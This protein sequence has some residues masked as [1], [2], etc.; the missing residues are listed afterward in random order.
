MIGGFFF[1]TFFRKL[2]KHK[3]PFCVLN[4][5]FVTHYKRQIFMRLALVFVVLVAHFSFGGK[6]QKG[7]AA[8]QE[9]NYFKAKQLFEKSLKRNASPASYGLAIIYFR[10]DNP[11][12]SLDSAKRF[13]LKAEENYKFVKEKDRVK[14]KLLGVDSLTIIET[15]RQISSGFFLRA[16][17]ENSIEAYDLFIR[18]HPWSNELVEAMHLRDSMLVDEALKAN[19]S[20]I[21]ADFLK[22]Y[23]TSEYVK[24]IQTA[25]Y[26]SQYDEITAAGSI[27]S[28]L[29][30]LSK[31]PDSPHRNKA[32][33][34]IYESSTA[35]NTIEVYTSFLETYPENI[36]FGNAWRKVY[37]LFMIDFSE[38]RIEQFKE[39]FPAYP[40]MDE[41]NADAEF[42][43]N[44]LLP[45]K[46]GSFYGFINFEG[47]QI[48]KAEYE[49][50]GFFKEGLAVAMKGGKYGYIDKGNRLVID[51]LFDN[52]SDFE[53][54]RAIVEINEKSGMID[55]AGNLVLE[56]VF[57]DLGPVSEGLLY[58]Q[59]DDLYGFYDINGTMKIQHKFSEAYSFVKGMA[60]VQIEDKQAFI[61]VYGSY[62][63]PPGYDNISF[64]SDTLL[65]FEDEDYLGLMQK[66]CAVTH[67]AAYEEIGPLQ[68]GR[69][70]MVQE[71]FIG[72]LDV[73]GKIAIPPK[74]E[75]Y[76][77]YLSKATFKGNCAIVMLKGKYG[78]IDKNG[79]LVV[80]AV[81]TNL[82]EI[83]ALVAFSKG[84]LWGFID[85]SGKEVIKPTYDY[86][87]S[88]V[89]GQAIVEKQ[90]L[91]G[92]ITSKG[93]EIIPFVFGSVNRFADN[94]YM[95]TTGSKF[96]MFDRT[97]IML[98]PLEY[99]QITR[100]DN[101]I[102]I[103]SFGEEIHYFYIPEER[104]IK[105][106]E[107]HE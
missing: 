81:Y 86:A 27:S 63:V 14:L 40:Y 73:T 10:T 76:P 45:F 20:A 11:F 31:C 51:Y 80:P 34:R 24:E 72:Y 91:Q 4:N 56:C 21:Y 82:G 33:N 75:I 107:V 28:Y 68:N 16:K 48:V 84:K 67:V 59:K 44:K 8:L 93:E 13:I 7:Y 15:T 30:F 1:D 64:F 100:V 3:Y 92:V 104:I 103:L 106:I 25:F 47:K 38:N 46:D 54:G 22:N 26:Q 77:N 58:A 99:T 23:P 61:D 69:A 96:G 66:N 19:K 60:K 102:L 39:Q 57:E 90:G 55:R 88:F 52:A 29:E 83:S 42:A 49:Y 2:L 32:E 50:L 6:I 53:S 71:D 37:Q 70:L 41:L 43:K 89:N 79:K 101:E 9:Y 65:I 18:E 35:L 36:N 62:M 97:G 87:E 5:S 78:I 105:P 95:V 85:L 98:V 12:H 94:Y 74:F 17:K